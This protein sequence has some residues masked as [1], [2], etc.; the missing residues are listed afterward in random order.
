MAIQRN[1]RQRKKM[2]LAEFQELGFLVK[3]NF[4]EGTGIDQ[5]DAIVD[6]FI[7]EVI[8]ANCL[9]YEGNGYL[10]WEGLV[11]LEKIGKCDESHR[12][13]VKTWLE[14]NGLQNVQVSE[15]FDIWW[16]FPAEA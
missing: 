2:H 13:L 16:D 15:L 7:D 8:K 1:A 6:R 3:F 5:I 14:N 10:A 9:A 4:A 12:Q 11:C